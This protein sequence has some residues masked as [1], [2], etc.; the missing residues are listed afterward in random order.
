MRLMQT[1]P[2]QAATIAGRRGTIQ[3]DTNYRSSPSSLCPPSVGSRLVNLHLATKEL[4]FDWSWIKTYQIGNDTNHAVS[5]LT[6]I[7]FI[8]LL[9]CIFSVVH[10]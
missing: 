7:L 8:L 2:P 3:R 10:Q 5:L 9:I 1:P 4:R 6:C